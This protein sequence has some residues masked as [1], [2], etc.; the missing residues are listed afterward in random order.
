LKDTV[1]V[2]VKAKGVAN[3]HFSTER[4]KQ[5]KVYPNP[6]V[7]ITNLELPDAGNQQ[8]A[9]SVTDVNGRQVRFQGHV[10]LNHSKS[11]Q[12]DMRGLQQ[13]FLYHNGDLP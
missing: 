8:L 6:V 13:G 5:L 7:D 12:L 4:L 9:I 3:D 1:Q 11:Y 10:N 2:T